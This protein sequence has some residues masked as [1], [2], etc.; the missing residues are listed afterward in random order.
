MTALSSAPY[1][2]VPRPPRET[3][4]PT[5]SRA[6]S[7]EI[8]LEPAGDEQGARQA[9][10][11]DIREEVRAALSAKRY[12]TTRRRGTRSR[13][14]PPDRPVRCGGDGVCNRIVPRRLG[15]PGPCPPR[16]NRG[17]GSHPQTRDRGTSARA[18]V[19]P[20]APKPEALR[21]AERRPGGPV[22]SRHVQSNRPS[23]PKS[24]TRPSSSSR[25]SGCSRCS[26]ASPGPAGSSA[27]PPRP[28][29]PEWPPPACATV[30]RVVLPGVRS[31]S[32]AA[33]CPAP[34]W[35]RRGAAANG[36]M[37]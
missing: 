27:H 5:S 18:C 33:R 7:A 6:G 37:R 29:G 17:C 22:V 35:A 19:E 36:P 4:S 2:A 16:R 26:M 21:R 30:D 14:R 3:T 34:T 32:R 10:P 8:H 11:Y 1:P 9:F 23:E 28:L 15:L 12:R 31:G 25:S 13:T 24:S 20:T